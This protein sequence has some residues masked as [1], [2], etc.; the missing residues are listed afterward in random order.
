MDEDED[1]IYDTTFVYNVC[2]GVSNA[3]Y[4]EV[5]R[6]GMVGVVMWM[7]GWTRRNMRCTT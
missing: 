6:G 3:S 4:A 5:G 2:A 1:M 7:D